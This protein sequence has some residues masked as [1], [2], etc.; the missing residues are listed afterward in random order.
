MRNACVVGGIP[1]LRRRQLLR[2]SFENP[3]GMADHEL[4]IELV[5]HD[6]FSGEV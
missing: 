1:A 3:G 4:L 6:K 5:V 2:G